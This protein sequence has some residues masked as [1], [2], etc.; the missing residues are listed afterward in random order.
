MYEL[1][2]RLLTEEEQDHLK[3]DFIHYLASN[4]ITGEDWDTIKANKP[5]EAQKHFAIFSD[6]VMDGALQNIQYI[7]LKKEDSIQLMQCFSDK[8]V[9]IQLDIA[10]E[11]DFSFS[12]K[13]NLEAIA[14]GSIGLDSLN[15]TIFSSSLNYPKERN[16]FI[17]SMLN[18]GY[19]PVSKEYWENFAKLIKK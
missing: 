14:N 15:P 1:K 9:I 7:E 19:Q 3:Q 18:Q 2:Y 13:E 6:M 11:M 4:S 17:F 8:A 12:K 16:L 10:P 5:Q